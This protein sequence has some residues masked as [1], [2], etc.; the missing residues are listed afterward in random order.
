MT[1]TSKLARASGAR[2]VPVFYYRE[3][4]LRDYVV[5]FGEPLP[6]PSGDDAADAACFNAWLEDRVRE[7][8]DQYLWLHKRFKTRPEGEPSVYR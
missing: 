4:S 2:V 6:I 5:R 7:Q 8:P 1:M 3:A